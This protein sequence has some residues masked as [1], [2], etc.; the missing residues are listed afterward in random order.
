MIV[1]PWVLAP[2]ISTGVAYASLATGLVPMTT[3][4]V[5]YTHLVCPV[6]VLKELQK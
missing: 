1:I 4:A 5:S 3:G 2:M 6:A